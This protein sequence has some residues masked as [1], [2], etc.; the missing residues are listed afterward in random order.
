MYF[1]LPSLLYCSPE[2][3]TRSELLIFSYH[4]AGRKEITQVRQESVV[5]RNQG[6][7]TSRLLI[8]AQH[9]KIGIFLLEHLQEC[10]DQLRIEL[11]AGPVL[12]L[13]YCPVNGHPFSVWTIRDHGIIGIGNAY[14][15]RSEG[16]LFS[17]Q[18]I[19]IA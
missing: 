5:I 3:G 15:A 18:A 14:D 19:R 17:L 10:I 12:Q 4:A 16:D 13:F 11:G 2:G 8:R 7:E 9:A 1:P 6:V